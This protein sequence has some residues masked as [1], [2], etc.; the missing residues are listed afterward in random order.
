MTQYG[1]LRMWAAVLTIMGMLGVL[2]AAAGTIVWAFE[3]DGFWQTVGVLLVG[4]PVS[5]FLATLPIAL[6]QALRALAD[7]GDTVSAR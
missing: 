6:A 7:V 3:V 2:L 5:I 1:T 4:G